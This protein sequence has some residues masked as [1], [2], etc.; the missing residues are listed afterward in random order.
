[1]D[2]S[3]DYVKVVTQLYKPLKM[4]GLL[5]YSYDYDYEITLF[6][7]QTKPTHTYNN[8]PVKN[9]LFKH[10]CLVMLGVSNC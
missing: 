7:T 2:F 1:M 4:H 8:S 3:V 9:I 5:V 6:E 10:V